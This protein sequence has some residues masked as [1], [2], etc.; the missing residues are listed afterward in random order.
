MNVTVFGGS[1]PRPG[2]TAYEQAQ[3]L[4]T[5]LAK[6][7]HTILRGGYTGTME[8]VSRGAAEA[9]GHV[10]GITC[11]EIEAWRPGGANQW[12]LEERSYKTLRARLYALVDGCD[13]ALALPGGIGTLAEIGVMW[14]QLQTSGEAPR[15]LILIGPGWQKALTALIEDHASY[16]REQDRALLGFAPDTDTAVQ[17]L[18]TASQ[19]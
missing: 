15:P 11:E 12:V 1:T 19:A 4:G 3:H 13:A 2:E 5:L 9:G 6:A 16:I 8:A 7:G 14:S 17:M 10:V 18:G